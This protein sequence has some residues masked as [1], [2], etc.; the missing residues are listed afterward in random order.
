MKKFLFASFLKNARKYEQAELLWQSRWRDL[1]DALGQQPLWES[2]W[3]DTRFADGTPCRDGNP[4]F[5]AVNRKR[6]L[7]IR[8]IQFE[9]G[10][11]PGEIS[12]WTDEFGQG[13]L[14]IKELVVSCALSEETLRQAMDLMRQWLSRNERR[15]SPSVKRQRSQKKALDRRS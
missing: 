1:V 12:H 13:R 14:A 7:G 15:R 10:N 11:D 9:P 5:S 4:I 8:V 2:P 3:H 6:R